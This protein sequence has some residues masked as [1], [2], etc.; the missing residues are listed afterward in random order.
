MN[1]RRS[2]GGIF[3]DLDN[4]FD[5]VKHGILVDKLQFYGIKG[6]FLAL[7]QSYL[8]GRNQKVF[9]DKLSAF[10]N[11]SSGWKK[12][13]NGIPQGSILG[14]LLFLVYINDLPMATDSDSKFVLFADDTSII[15]TSPNR[16]RLQIALNKT[17]SDINSWFQANFL[18]LNFNKT[19]YL[20]FQTKNYIDNT[21]DMNYLNKTI[22]NLL[23][24]NFL[25]LV[26][27]DT[28]TWNNHIDQLISKFNS[29]CYAIKAVNAVL[30]RKAL[31]V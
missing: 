30:S 9:I 28:L 18:L 10:D 19:Y 26:V 23:Y 11:V 12:I 20:Q 2:V 5:C 15:I 22:A 21:L 25:G 16:E 1:N 7:I 8:R 13:T 3:C 27:D 14:T 17:L 4:A 31:R 6:K 24:T 29:A